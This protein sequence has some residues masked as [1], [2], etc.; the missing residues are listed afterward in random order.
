MKLR[1]KLTVK[2]VYKS[3]TYIT[4]FCVFLLLAAM[5]NLWA[6]NTLSE[7]A[8]WGWYI[9]HNAYTYA[10]FM[11]IAGTGRSWKK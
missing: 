3:L 11:L 4:L 7:H 9:P 2:E 1:N 5:L 10:A 8:G 6:F